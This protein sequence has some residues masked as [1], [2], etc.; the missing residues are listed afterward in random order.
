MASLLIGGGVHV[1]ERGLNGL[2]TSHFFDDVDGRP[3][4]RQPCTEGVPQAMPGHPGP[5]YL[6]DLIDVPELVPVAQR[7]I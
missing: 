1:T 7:L 2:V 5:W 3:R 6:G 4:A